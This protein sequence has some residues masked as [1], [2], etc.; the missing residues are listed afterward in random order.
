MK[1]VL[2]LLLF[3]FSLNLVSCSG[4]DNLIQ[5]AA[6]EKLK[7]TVGE[8]TLKRDFVYK[9]DKETELKFDIYCSAQDQDES[10]PPTVVL[11]HGIA[12]AKSLKD[13]VVFKKWGK[14]LSEEGFNAIIFNWRPDRSAKDITDFFKYIRDNSDKLGIDGDNIKV[15]AFS[16]GVKQGVSEVTDINTGFIKSIAVFYGRI[17]PS[18]LESSGEKLPPMFIAMGAA[19]RTVPENI[20]DSFIEEAEKAGCSITK[21]VH[22]TGGHGFDQN[23]KIDETKEIINRAIMFLRNDG[24]V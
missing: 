14:R 1:R 4:V 2:L 18:V 9:V 12:D 19:D 3:V 11:I 8:I 7:G 15:I 16:A 23:D 20:N 6:Q 5:P 17:S 13:A 21:V 22:S 24:E 10:N